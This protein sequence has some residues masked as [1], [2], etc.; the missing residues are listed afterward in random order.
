MVGPA[1][2]LLEPINGLVKFDHVYSKPDLLPADTSDLD[3]IR[4]N[5]D[6]AI[7]SFKDI[8]QLE[9][10]LDQ[11]FASEDDSVKPID[12][13]INKTKDCG[14]DVYDAGQLTE[15]LSDSGYSDAC[16]PYSNLAASPSSATSMLDDG[17][18]EESFSEL[19]PNLV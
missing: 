16:S 15:S 17:I 12:L 1:S 18:W 11:H 14:P 2:E 8:E 10:M 19:F 13:S 4:L 9:E 6:E 7:L 3:K 5:V